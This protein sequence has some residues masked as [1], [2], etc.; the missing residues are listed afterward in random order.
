[1]K[2]ILSGLVLTPFLMSACINSGEL[3]Q[4]TDG[5]L[6]LVTQGE[7][8]QI[9]DLD[10]QRIFENKIFPNNTPTAP[11][12]RG[13][14][15]FAVRQDLMETKDVVKDFNKILTESKFE[16]ERD[17]A[18]EDQANTTKYKDFKTLANGYF[19][20]QSDRPNA[21]NKSGKNCASFNQAVTYSVKNAKFSVGARQVEGIKIKLGPSNCSFALKDGSAEFKVNSEYTFYTSLPD[22]EESQ[23]F[24]ILDEKRTVF[25]SGNSTFFDKYIPKNDDG[26]LPFTVKIPGGDKVEAVYK[27]RI[28]QDFN[29][30][31][32]KVLFDPQSSVEMLA[33]LETE[34]RHH[35]SALKRKF[36]ALSGNDKEGVLIDSFTYGYHIKDKSQTFQ[37]NSISPLDQGT[38]QYNKFN[39]YSGMLLHIDTST[40]PVGQPVITNIKANQGLINNED[41]FGFTVTTPN[42][43]A[44]SVLTNTVANGKVS[45]KS[46]KDFDNDTASTVA[47]AFDST[48]TYENKKW[49]IA[50]LISN[51]IR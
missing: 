32:T 37:I 36:E 40:D 38:S 39:L 34:E 8:Q 6:D 13:Y 49:F 41:G 50:S 16:L 22:A 14:T 43:K 42:H 31:S 26:G 18:T 2:K 48:Y 23:S 45:F 25:G 33:Q 5:A 29:G 35:Y 24:T 17:L 1:M 28:I 7:L 3:Y 12:A 27:E 15:G 11:A 21:D 30:T 46:T 10:I 47:P 44:S 9:G 4:K 19:A 51:Y 20:Y